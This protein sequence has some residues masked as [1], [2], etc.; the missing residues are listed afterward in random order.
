[1]KNKKEIVLTFPEFITHIPQTKKKMDKNW[2][3]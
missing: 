2:I 1:M 3:Q